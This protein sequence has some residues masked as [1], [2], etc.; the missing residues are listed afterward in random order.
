MCAVSIRIEYDSTQ[1]EI[2]GV[3]HCI[4]KLYPTPT[5]Y[6]RAIPGPRMQ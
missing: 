4:Y 3:I 1:P 2:G 5:L 6:V